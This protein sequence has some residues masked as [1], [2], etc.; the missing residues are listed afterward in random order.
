MAIRAA[1]RCGSRTTTRRPSL[2]DVDHFKE[3]NDTFGHSVGDDV[4]RS[5][6]HRLQT[7]GIGGR[8]PCAARLGGDEFGGAAALSAGSRH[9]HRFPD[10]GGADAQP[11]VGCGVQVR[12]S[13]GFA[14]TRADTGELGGLLGQAGAAMY[15][16]KRS[17]GALQPYRAGLDDYPR[18]RGRHRPRGTHPQS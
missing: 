10:P 18:D 5:V 16:A 8:L 13:A 4:V 6:G 15:R 17:S 2:I 14:T 3:I 1:T 9:R 7:W 12:L 11:V